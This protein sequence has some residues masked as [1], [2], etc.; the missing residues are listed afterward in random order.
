[1]MESHFIDTSSYDIVMVTSG[2]QGYKTQSLS[3]A[4]L[5]PP[6]LESSDLELP[7]PSAG[8]EP[9]LWPGLWLGLESA[10]MGPAVTSASFPSS[11]PL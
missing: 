1:M 7:G 11:S 4:V 5:D 10:W 9:E 6:G 2:K 3:L 8:L